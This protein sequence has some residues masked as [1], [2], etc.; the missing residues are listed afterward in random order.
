MIINLVKSWFEDGF[1]ILTLRE[2]IF[3]Q[4]NIG[5]DLV[6]TTFIDLLKEFIHYCKRFMS[7]LQ[8]Y[9]LL[10]FILMGSWKNLCYFLFKII[11]FYWFFFWLFVLLSG[12]HVE[13]KTLYSFCMS[14]VNFI[15]L[16]EEVYEWRYGKRCAW[17][18]ELFDVGNYIFNLF[19]R[20]PFH[21]VAELVF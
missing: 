4:L 15:Y 19:I 6:F 5:F 8:F 21:D 17:V 13:E 14:N 18:R 9:H 20:G 16:G 7:F 3:Y 10:L 11:S 1:M 12:F 2:H